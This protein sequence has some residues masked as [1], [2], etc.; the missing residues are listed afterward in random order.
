MVISFSTLSSRTSPNICCRFSRVWLY[1]LLAILSVFIFHGIF[2]RR[3]EFLSYTPSNIGSDTAS[4]RQVV[5]IGPGDLG[6]NPREV[7]P[8]D[9]QSPYAHEPV[10]LGTLRDVR[11]DN[12]YRGGTL[13]L[14]VG[15]GEAHPSPVVF[16]PYPD[17]NGNE[18]RK[19]STGSFRACEGPRGYTLNRWSPEDMMTVYPSIPKGSAIDCHVARFPRKANKL[20]DFPLS[21]IGSYSAMGIDS[22]V[23]TNRYSRLNAYGYESNSSQGTFDVWQPPRMDWDNVRWGKLQLQCSE[24]NANRYGRGV[25]DM[26]AVHFL[27]D[28]PPASSQQIPRSQPSSSPTGAQ[29]KARSAVILRAWHDMEWTENLKQYIR[30]LIMELS[31]HSGGE[32]EIFILCHVRDKKISLNPE[33]VDAIWRLKTRFV[34]V[35]FVDMTILFNDQILEAWYPKI[36]DHSTKTQYWQP[37]QIFSQ[38]FQEFDYYWQ[39]EMDSRFTGHVYHFLEQAAKFA[40]A[41]PRKYLWERNSYF[42]IPGA[43][44]TWQQFTRMVEASMKGR[45]SIWGPIDLSGF[46]PVGS[47]ADNGPPIIAVGPKPPVASPEDDNYKWGVDEEGDLITFLP[48]FDPVRTRWVFSDVIGNLRGDIPRQASPVAMGRISKNLAQ[49]M[50]NAQSQLGIILASEMTAPTLALWHGLKAVYVPQPVY[51]DGKWTSKE[52]G[53]ILNPGAPEKIN[54][55]EDSIWNWDHRWDHILY[56]LS[57]MF[58]TQSAED[59]YRRWMGFKIDPLQ[60]T[61]GTYHQDPQGR[62]WFETG[63]LREDLYGPLCFPSMLLHPVK[64]TDVKKGSSMAVP[65]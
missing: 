61:D 63:D 43:H 16:D 35:E 40:K 62:N 8:Q 30:S 41:Q 33:D 10:G 7:R 37:V 60:Y 28:S 32:Y 65:V 21:L 9:D 29:Y 4:N 25:T 58:S 39:L 24:L 14:D 48:T 15:S 54:G 23:C 12:F 26:Q 13:T 52:L 20:V 64:N 44:G 42:F 51:V 57:Y 36:E 56:R 46:I 31:L 17:Y 38:I 47:T 19:E 45:G 5:I 34:P 49:Q 3:Q 59:F 53:R 27:P 55:G 6:S 22:S 50:H 2:V 11:E 18:W 1:V